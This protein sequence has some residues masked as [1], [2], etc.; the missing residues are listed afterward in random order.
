MRLKLK[1]TD[2]TAVVRDPRTKRALAA[3]GSWVKGSIFWQRRIVAGE[4]EVLETQDLASEKAADPDD[5]EELAPAPR[6]PTGLEPT[7]PLTTRGRM[8]LPGDD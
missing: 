3:E 7:T 1:P 4:V 6:T 5:A 2:A 8:P